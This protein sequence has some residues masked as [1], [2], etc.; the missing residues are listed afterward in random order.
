MPATH[1]E[2]VHHQGSSSGIP[3]LSLTTKGSWRRVAKPLVNPLTPGSGRNTHR[4]IRSHGSKGEHHDVTRIGRWT[5]DRER[6]GR[7]GR[8][9]AV[10]AAR[11]IN[12]SSTGRKLLFVRVA[13]ASRRGAAYMAVFDA[14]PPRDTDVSTACH[15]A[16]PDRPAGQALWKEGTRVRRQNLINIMLAPRSL[17]RARQQYRPIIAAVTS[18]IAG[19]TV[20]QSSAGGH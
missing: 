1:A 6:K 4:M 2:A 5:A 13:V 12:S 3:S 11:R 8:I 9:N 16:P 18:G 15:V 17:V 14:S 19:Y 10:G 20:A 7:N